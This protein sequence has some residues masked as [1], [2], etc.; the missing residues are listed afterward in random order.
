MT[1][2]GPPTEK[3]QGSPAGK[4]S[5]KTVAGLWDAIPLGLERDGRSDDLADVR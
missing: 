1:T 3:P 4:Q 2:V 5:G